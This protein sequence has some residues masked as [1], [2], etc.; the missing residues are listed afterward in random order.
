MSTAWPVCAAGPG[1]IALRHRGVMDPAV[2]NLR[3]GSPRARAEARSEAEGCSRPQETGRRK[4]D[5]FA[6]SFL[7]GKGYLLRPAGAMTPRP[8]GEG[9]GC[10]AEGG[11]LRLPDHPVPKPAPYRDT[12]AAVTSGEREAVCLR[13]GRC[14]MRGVRLRWWPG[15]GRAPGEEPKTGR[16]APTQKALTPSKSID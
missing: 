2:T 6:G 11:P 1:L 13:A 14:S 10:A 16:S 12:T 5:R 9:R 15:G 8:P 4:D 7:W 3:P